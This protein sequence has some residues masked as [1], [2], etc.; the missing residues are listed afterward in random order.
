MVLLTFHGF[1]FVFSQDSCSFHAKGVDHPVLRFA[2]VRTPIFSAPGPLFYKPAASFGHAFWARASRITPSRA[3][4][5]ST[6]YCA[7]G[8]M[9][10]G[11]GSPCTPFGPGGGTSAGSP[12]AAPCGIMLPGDGRVS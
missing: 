5:G 9:R 10:G 8:G 6:Q 4:R 11:G 2:R 7:G 1:R 12:P 3:G